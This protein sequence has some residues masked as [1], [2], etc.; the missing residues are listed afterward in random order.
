M[1]PP[2]TCLSLVFNLSAKSVVTEGNRDGDHCSQRAG[3]L[4]PILSRSPLAP[5]QSSTPGVHCRILGEALGQV[6]LNACAAGSEK[7]EASGSRGYLWVKRVLDLFTAE[8]KKPRNTLGLMRWAQCCVVNLRA[9]RGVAAA[10]QA[11]AATDLVLSLVG[12][13]Y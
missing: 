5:W 3:Q 13:K 6:G 12:H 2:V 9:L 7:R 4:I 1:K 11:L 8:A 10:H